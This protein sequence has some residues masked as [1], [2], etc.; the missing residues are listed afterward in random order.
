MTDFTDLVNWAI[1]AYPISQYD[2]FYDWLG[3]VEGDLRRSGHKPH[4][5]WNDAVE[6]MRNYWN[7]KTS[8]EVDE[9]EDYNEYD[10]YHEPPERT[11]QIEQVQRQEKNAQVEVYYT[12]ERIEYIKQ[13]EPEKFELKPLPEL[14]KAEKFK[15]A[16]RYRR[17]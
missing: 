6:Q 12:K 14:S 11:K 8:Q 5:R 1:N 17:K 16:K 10:D 3:D 15:N 7:N 9:R 2:S 4:N 13:Q